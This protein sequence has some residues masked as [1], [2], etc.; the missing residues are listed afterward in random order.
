MTISCNISNFLSSYLQPNQNWDSM[1][2]EERKAQI[3]KQIPTTQSSVNSAKPQVPAQVDHSLPGNRSRNGNYVLGELSS[4][5]LR[6]DAYENNAETVKTAVLALQ[7]REQLSQDSSLSADV[8]EAN[9]QYANVIRQW[10]VNQS[11]MMNSSFLEHPEVLLDLGHSGY[12]G[13]N[14]QRDTNYVIQLLGNMFSDM[15]QEELN[16]KGLADM[17]SGQMLD[18]LNQY[19]SVL[20]RVTDQIS[21]ICESQTGHSL[22]G[23]AKANESPKKMDDWILMNFG[24]QYGLDSKY[25]P[26]G[27][28]AFT[29]ELTDVPEWMDHIFDSLDVTV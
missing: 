1:T 29:T 14:V 21:A 25:N 23:Y 8:R 22:T 4:A 17:T 15:S 16:I 24:A 7:N 5:Y 28:F 27:G 18:A 12:T 26:H 13:K 10:I 3:L 20:D 6:L 9:S 2:G 19:E 11:S